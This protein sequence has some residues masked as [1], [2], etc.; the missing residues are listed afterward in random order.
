M[1][2]ETLAG[3]AILGG[4]YPFLIGKRHTPA[5]RSRQR[6]K[7]LVGGKE[8][9]G[10]AHSRSYSGLLLFL[11]SNSLFFMALNFSLNWIH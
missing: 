3:L 11:S 2:E 1:A 8:K 7:I 10:Q 6:A 5:R 4:L 9:G